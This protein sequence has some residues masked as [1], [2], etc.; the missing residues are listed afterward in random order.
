MIRRVLLTAAGLFT[1][2]CVACAPAE[3]KLPP[4]HL[5]GLHPTA[6]A[7]DNIG[8]LPVEFANPKNPVFDPVA[9]GTPPANMVADMRQAIALAPPF[10]QEQLCQ[11]DGLFIAPRGESWGVRN[12]Q[13]GKRYV[14]LS[15]DLWSGGSP[16]DLATRQTQVIRRLADWDGPSVTQQPHNPSYAPAITV[17]DVLAHE[18]GH[19]LFYD[20]FVNRPGTKPDFNNPAFCGGGFFKVSWQQNTLPQT[21]IPWR[22][23]TDIV[24]SHLSDDIQIDEVR[25]APPTPSGKGNLLNLFYSES[26]TPKERNGH[27][28]W[29]SLFAGFTPDHDFI[30]TF[31]LFV[32]MKSRAPLT[33]LQ[34]NVPTANGTK[35]HN[36]PASC[37]ARSALKGKLACFQQKFCRIS[38]AGPCSPV[39][40]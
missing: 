6:C 16:P 37:N 34:I 13:T 33:T 21:A 15:A 1:A 35:Q 18:F 2:V 8:M 40:S 38:G 14:A 10:F 20:T 36:I 39:C 5:V 29:A 30:E 12:P 32:L 19:V 22:G 17:L 24:S 7:Y 31:R 4:Q 3:V 11:L 23:Y 9:S 26:A 27:G 25:R 28:R